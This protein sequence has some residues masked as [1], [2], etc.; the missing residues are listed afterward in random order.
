MLIYVTR[1]VLLIFPTLLILSLIIFG[2]LRILPGD[3]ATMILG[4]GE[5]GKVSEASI[6]VIQEKLGLN[7]PLHIQYFDWL[8]DTMRGDFGTS[9]YSDQSV[10]GQ[11]AQRIPL[12]LEIAIFAKLVSIL[13][14]VP[15]GIISA[16]KQNS[17]IDL[18]LRFM[19]IFFLAAPSFWL[20]LLVILGG[21]LWF[22]WIP[23]LGYN[24]IWKDPVANFQQLIWPIIILS[25]NGLAV[26]ARMTR[27]SMLEVMRED[28]IRTAR[29]KGLAENVVIMRHALKNALIPVVTLAGL[30][31]AALLGGT[32]II[33]YIFGIPGIGSYFIQA[34][35]T[36]DYPV[37]QGMVIAF[38]IV[39]MLINL[40]VDLLYGWLDPRISYS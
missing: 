30:Q 39:F 15:I 27:S 5:G 22:N 16:I 24:P 19:T 28:F 17:F 31:F 9:L 2:L 34:I 40:V 18:S 14:G 11:L 38:A 21:A 13:V 25:H 32:V 33:E 29:A 1:R 12:T 35:Q 6:R 8:W 36:K 4:G 23:P 26:I 7:R 20:G 3:V 37:V 10:G